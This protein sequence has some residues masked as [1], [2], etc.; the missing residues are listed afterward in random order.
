MNVTLRR[1][2][3]AIVAVEKQKEYFFVRVSA[4]G[5][6]C[7]SSMECACAI[8]YH[9]WPL[10]LRQFF[11]TLSRKRHDFS[12]ASGSDSSVAVVLRCSTAFIEVFIGAAVQS[13][14][15]TFGAIPL[16]C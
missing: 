5:E 6:L 16:C 8:L 12:S 4:G 11:P 1:F 13:F 10:W 3:E 9:L 15:G 7:L 14:Y 2:R